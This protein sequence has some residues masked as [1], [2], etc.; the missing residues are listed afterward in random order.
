LTQI[1]GDCD[2][3]KIKFKRLDFEIYC[4]AY[5]H[6]TFH[7]RFQNRQT[8]P[9]NYLKYETYY[10][11]PNSLLFFHQ[12]DMQL[13]HKMV[14]S[15]FTVCLRARDYI[16]RLSQHPWYGLWMRVKGPHHYKVT[17]LG[18]CVKWPLVGSYVTLAVASPCLLIRV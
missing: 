4:K 2:F 10:I 1:P 9:T 11:E 7:Y 3:L 16:K 12:Q 8:P 5:F 6:S 17:A 18:S 14:H 15:H 13:S